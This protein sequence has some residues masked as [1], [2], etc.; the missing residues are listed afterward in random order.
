MHNRKLKLVEIQ[1]VIYYF[2]KDFKNTKEVN[3]AEL[4]RSPAIY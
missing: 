2:N 4:N 3:L 1:S